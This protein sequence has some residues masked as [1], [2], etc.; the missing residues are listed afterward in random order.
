MTLN[1]KPVTELALS[2]NSYAIYCGD[3]NIGTVIQLDDHTW[4][5]AIDG[6]LELFSGKKL[7]M[8]RLLE[9]YAMAAFSED[10]FE[11]MA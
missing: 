2:D 9:A 6:G 7:A 11:S 5:V 1:R 10:N 3:E 4:Q 8:A